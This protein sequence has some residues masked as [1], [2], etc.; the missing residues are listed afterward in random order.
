MGALQASAGHFALATLTVALASIWVRW[1]FIRQGAGQRVDHHYWLLAA[2]AFRR[3]SRLPIELDGRYLMEPRAQAYPPLFGWLLARLPPALLASSRCV[4]VSQAADGLAALIVI[5]LGLWMGIGWT[6]ALVIV[7]TLSI[8]PILV[9]YNTQLNPRSFGN[10]F[11]VAMLACEVVAVN[12]PLHTA[13]PMWALAMLLAAGVWLTHKMTIQLMLAL[14]LPWAIALGSGWAVLVPVMGLALA[15][16][17]AGPG[18]MLYQL[19]AHVDIVRFWTRN[20]SYLGIHPIR[21]SPIYGQPAAARSGALHAQGW[22]NVV[23]QLRLMVGYAPL[24]VLMPLALPFGQAAPAWLLVWSLGT[25]LWALA[26]ALWGRLKG[27]GSGALYLFNGVIPAALWA[28]L[29][30]E[31]DD[32]G[33]LLAFGA[34]TAISLVALGLGWRQRQ[35]RRGATEAQFEAILAYLRTQPPQRLAVFPLN[36]VDA[37]AAGTPHSVLWGAHGYSFDALEPIFPRVTQRLAST[38]ARYRIGRVVWS[39]EFWPDAAA[40][41]AAELELGETQEFGVWRTAR[42]RGLPAAPRLRVAIVLDRSERSPGACDASASLAQGAEEFVLSLSAEGGAWGSRVASLIGLYRRLRQIGP[43]MVD[44]RRA[45]LGALIA[46][47]FAGIPH[48]VFR[49]PLTLLERRLAGGGLA[50]QLLPPDAPLPLER[51]GG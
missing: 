44:C 35:A 13:W 45:G 39:S 43:H 28:G 4:W 37:V 48:R 8:S 11:L 24:L 33:A 5:A 41:L 38:F 36:A 17:V 15:A 1:L 19:A 42:V 3:A 49:P 25:L 12:L 40:V 46:A 20:W 32:A 26:T 9:S 7:A 23:A 22:R 29:S 10:L 30:V 51:L 31:R 2:E 14:W 50:S 16:A 21:H 18:A 6:G 47:N 27:L 34:A